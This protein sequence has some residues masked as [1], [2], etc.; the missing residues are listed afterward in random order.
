MGALSVRKRKGFD[1]AFK[2]EAVRLADSSEKPDLQIE[3]E[4]GIYQGAIRHWRESIGRDPLNAFPGTGHATQIEEE[5]RRVK[6]E[7]DIFRQERD[8]LKKAV[9][10]FSK[11]PKANTDL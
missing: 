1:A 11:T 2:R 8:I 9:A 3:R 5:L 6:R 7:R 10:I 4:L